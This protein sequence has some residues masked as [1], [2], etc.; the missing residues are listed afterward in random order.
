MILRP[1]S[2]AAEEKTGVDVF[3]QSFKVS[4]SF[5]VVFTRNLFSLENKHLLGVLGLRE[6]SICHRCL[7][8]VDDG[9]AH[10]TPCLIPQILSYAAENAQHIDLV[11]GPYLLPGGEAIKADSAHLAYVQDLIHEHKIDRHSFVIGI[12]GGA[13]LDAV[14]FA[15]AT[16][17]RGV[18]HI[19]VPTTTLAQN[20]SG[21]GVKNAVNF[22]RI[23]NYLGTFAPPWAVLNDL[24]LLQGLPPRER[25]AGLA[26]AVKVS[27]IR[28]HEFFKWIEANAAGLASFDPVAEEFMIRRCA[29]LHM[30]QIAHGGDPFETGSA[31]PLDFG[32]W[33]AHRL[34]L[35]THHRLRHGE[36]VAIG[37]AH[38]TY[39]SV[40][41]GLLQPGAEERVA[42]L[43]E[44]LGFFLWD[45]ALDHRDDLGR[46]E[47]IQ[48]L[49][50]FREHLGG[51]LTITLLEDIGVGREVNHI[52]TSGL[53]ASV[54][55]LRSRGRK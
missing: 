40:H 5:P 31:R 25:R 26:E 20:D 8:F 22:N 53:L 37:I 24:D 13:L 36:A 41:S 11:A 39:Y 9:V 45:S 28:D 29:Q 3:W 32:H 38:D 54:D 4:Y 7:F 23:K 1:S 17:H 49:D 21:V 47:I 16:A 42:S 12:G 34:E 6:P 35:L 55:W 33:L 44:A 30:H 19:R 52:D 18:R 15:A 27:L 50:E 43:L 2:L 51:Q 14:G 46:L 10:S 48:G